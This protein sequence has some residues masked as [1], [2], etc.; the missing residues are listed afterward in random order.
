[1]AKSKI[2]ETEEFIEKTIKK[3]NSDI[4][5][6][7]KQINIDSKEI[8]KADKKLNAA[9]RLEDFEKAKAEKMHAENSKEMHEMQV[10]RLKNKP[11]INNDKFKEMSGD[12]MDEI[13]A[14]NDADEERVKELLT[15]LKEIA[16]LNMEFKRRGNTAVLRLKD[17]IARSSDVSNLFNNVK[18]AL[19]LNQ[20]SNNP[21]FKELTG[22]KYN[23]IDLQPCNIIDS[24]RE[25]PEF[26]PNA[27]RNTRKGI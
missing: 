9:E 2:R 3:R 18:L 14:R 11:L 5:K 27:I 24:K 7:E 10:S 8:I 4:A 12:I 22:I 6:L 17:E 25:T 13:K 21:Y 20:I 19:F 26:I 23:A 15:E 1:M 16:T